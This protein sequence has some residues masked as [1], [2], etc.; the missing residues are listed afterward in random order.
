M[1]SIISSVSTL[2]EIATCR[3]APILDGL[4]LEVVTCGSWHPGPCII[5]VSVNFGSARRIWKFRDAQD[6]EFP[7][8]TAHY[9]EHLLMFANRHT[10]LGDLK[11][12]VNGIVKE[13]S[14]ILFAQCLL[15][16]D[17]AAEQISDVVSKLIRSLVT[18]D[19]S[20]DEI[21]I[22]IDDTRAD[23][24]NE[25]AYRHG[26][27]DYRLRR[28]ILNCLYL[29]SDVRHDPLGDRA[30]LETIDAYNVRLA[31]QVICDN[32]VAITVFCREI[33]DD[34]GIA[35]ET[36]LR[37]L[38]NIA[39]P[40]ESIKLNRSACDEPANIAQFSEGFQ[41]SA[42]SGSVARVLTGIK[43]SPP[44]GI[45]KQ[46]R[47][48]HA[49]FISYVIS[50][51]L[52]SRVEVFLCRDAHVYMLRATHPTPR[53]FWDDAHTVELATKLRGDIVQR[54]ETYRSYFDIWTR[55]AFDKISE[56]PRSLFQLFLFASGCGVP[57]CQ[58][59]SALENVN[60]Q[61]IELLLD[62]L[63][64]AAPHFAIAYASPFFDEL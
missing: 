45:Y 55:S 36:Q 64:C 34:I 23:V 5:A 29:K 37:D 20:D 8:G 33:P 49:I 59:L 56:G 10:I 30:S 44:C 7:R 39:R 27:L 50:S 40:T 52:R 18:L 4:P 12:F 15:G 60:V 22:M 54:C 2:D 21:D 43:L 62:E 57:F 11:S 38:P 58:M 63:E 31:H 1:S 46:D 24:I 6:H 51:I 42:M 48:A 28:S 61:S 14:T 35:L 53:F 13:D 19:K 41:W 32:I 16:S 47:L 25:I 26:L 9:M 3:V 17:K